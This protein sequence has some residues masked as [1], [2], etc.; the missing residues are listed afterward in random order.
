MN[1]EVGTHGESGAS[2]QRHAGK[3][4][5]GGIEFVLLLLLVKT[6]KI[7]LVILLSLNFARQLIV[8]VCLADIFENSQA[9]KSPLSIPIDLDN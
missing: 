1:P 4:R 7:A 8:K 2:V 6:A 3:A 9:F 5:D